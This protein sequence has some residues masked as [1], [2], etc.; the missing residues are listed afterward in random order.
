MTRQE[1]MAFGDGTNDL[2]MFQVVGQAVVMDNASEAIKA[3][4]DYV[5]LSNQEDGVAHA[6][7]HYLPSLQ[8]K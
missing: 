2:A 8:D 7:L 4:A 3:Q 5:T 1:L 6:L